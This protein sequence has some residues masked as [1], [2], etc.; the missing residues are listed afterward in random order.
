MKKGKLTESEKYLMELL[1]EMDGAVAMPSIMKA[2]TEVRGWKYSTVNTLLVRMIEKGYLLKEKATYR[3]AYTKEGYREL[4][5][6][7]FMEEIHENSVKN[8]M[9]ALTGKM[10]LSQEELEDLQQWLD[11]QKEAVDSDPAPKS[12]KK[13]KG[14]K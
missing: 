11:E 7:D 9:V 12:K 10:K 14:V 6:E 13:A 8:L 5:T 2:Q 4:E 1:W 3:P